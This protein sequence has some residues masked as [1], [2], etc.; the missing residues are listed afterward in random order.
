M[1][2]SI[3][4]VIAAVVVATVLAGCGERPQVGKYEQGEYAGKADQRPWDGG[5]FKGDKGAWEQAQRNRIRTQN[6]YKRVE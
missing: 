6:E 2:A 1:K 3:P 5:T 4:Y